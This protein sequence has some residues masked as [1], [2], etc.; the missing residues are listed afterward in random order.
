MPA[1]GQRD[2]VRA[3][4]Q[5]GY[6]GGV[7]SQQDFFAS[8]SLRH[9]PN[10]FAPERVYRLRKEGEAVFLGE[11]VDHQE[12]DATPGWE[13]ACVYVA[14]L[15]AAGE[16]YIQHRATTKRLWPD[17]KTISASGHVDPGETFEQA[18]VREVQEEL[19]IELDPLALHLVGWFMGLAHSGPVYEAR[20]HRT[21]TP[22]PDELTVA[23]SGFLPVLQLERMLADPNLFTPSGRRALQVWLGANRRSGAR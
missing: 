19:G 20:S 12:A 13:Q 8:T 23:Q 3:C 4:R 1:A 17:R 7:N 21:P 9:T 14:I 18:A 15:N 11:L 16:I 10:R 22:N 6:H 2:G 5:V